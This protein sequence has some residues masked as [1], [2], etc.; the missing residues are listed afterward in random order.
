LILSTST[1]KHKNS[2]EIKIRGKEHCVT[3]NQTVF[4]YKPGKEILYLREIFSG[5][6]KQYTVI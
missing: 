6:E 2:P 1:P 3:R 5:I 4:K